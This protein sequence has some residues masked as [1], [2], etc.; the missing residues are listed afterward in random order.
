MRR[1]V[2]ECEVQQS[3]HSDN[4]VPDRLNSIQQ[5]I[6]SSGMWLK[7]PSVLET[8]VNACGDARCLQQRLT[9]GGGVPPSGVNN[10]IWLRAV[11]KLRHCCLADRLPKGRGQ[12]MLVEAGPRTHYLAVHSRG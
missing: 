8:G 4:T 1:E 7:I 5:L 11:I 10:C 12:T 2:I 6:Y 3:F 9:V